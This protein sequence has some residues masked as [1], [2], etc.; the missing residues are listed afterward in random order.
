M[1]RRITAGKCLGNCVCVCGRGGGGGGSDSERDEG[2]RKK[3]KRHTSC[4]HLGKFYQV[5]PP[6]S[7]LS[8]SFKIQKKK[9]KLRT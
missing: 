6:A 9:E 5:R 8:S 3:N 2:V 4:Y 1:G 7:P